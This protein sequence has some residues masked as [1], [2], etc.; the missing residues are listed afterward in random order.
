MGTMWQ[1]AAINGVAFVAV[2]LRVPRRGESDFMPRAKKRDKSTEFE[3][4]LSGGF[5]G[6][7]DFWTERLCMERHP[8]RSV[9]LSSRSNEILAEAG[10]YI[11]EWG[12]RKSLPRTI[13]RK[14]VVGFDGDYVVGEKLLPHDGAAVIT[15]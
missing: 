2:P 11:D 4:L 13:N 15:V 7:H 5:W 9:T 10:R 6:A 3:I 1:I 14:A 12:H 8:N